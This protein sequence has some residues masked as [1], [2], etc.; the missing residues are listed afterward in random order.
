MVVFIAII[1]QTSTTASHFRCFLCFSFS[2]GILSQSALNACH[3]PRL[4]FWKCIIGMTICCKKLWHLN[5][6]CLCLWLIEAYWKFLKSHWMTVSAW[7]YWELWM[8]YPNRVEACIQIKSRTKHQNQ[9]ASTNHAATLCFTEMQTSP[10]QVGMIWIFTAFK[11][12]YGVALYLT[13]GLLGFFLFFGGFFSIC[14]ILSF[15]SSL[16]QHSEEESLNTHGNLHLKNCSAKSTVELDI[17]KV[18]VI[19]K[20]NF[21]HEL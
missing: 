13:V 5:N 15:N 17:S 12:S 1:T 21:W 4:L 3:S 2:S 19:K 8:R 20:I 7:M 18:L 16:K 9:V 14:P 6:Y 10:I 11:I